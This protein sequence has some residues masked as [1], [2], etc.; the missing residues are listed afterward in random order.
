[1]FGKL[2]LKALQMHR[3][4][5]LSADVVHAQEMVSTLPV[6]KTAKEVRRHT[7]I[8]P[9]DV[10]V[11]RIPICVN[12]VISVTVFLILIGVCIFAG[13]LVRAYNSLLLF[14]RF[15]HL[16]VVVHY[17]PPQLFESDVSE[18]VILACSQVQN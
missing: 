16:V 8:S 12:C 18:K 13:R 11:V 1:M 15:Q 6:G 7:A 10:P 9:K 5:A 14:R 3:Q 17:F 4:R 2:L